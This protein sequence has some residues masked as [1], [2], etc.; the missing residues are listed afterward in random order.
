MKNTILRLSTCLIIGALAALAVPC[1]AAGLINPGFED[2]GIPGDP[3]PGWAVVAN[4]DP[5]ATVVTGGL[6][7]A[8]MLQFP[9]SGCSVCNLPNT[10]YSGALWQKFSAVQ[11]KYYHV[12]CARSLGFQ[13][14]GANI[15]LGVDPYGGDVDETYSNVFWWTAPTGTGPGIW[16][17]VGGWIQC[18]GNSGQ[19]TV[20]LRKDTHTCGDDH[21]D[22]VLACEDYF[23]PGLVN[24]DFESAFSYWYAGP[25]QLFC[26]T[27]GWDMSRQWEYTSD[28]YNSGLSRDTA[29]VA[30]GSPL[31]SASLQAWFGHAGSGNPNN[32]NNCLCKDIAWP[33]NATGATITV[34]AKNF[35]PDNGAVMLGVIPDAGNFSNQLWQDTL[36]H[37]DAA[38]ADTE[39][40][41]LEVTVAKPSSPGY[42]TVMLNAVPNKVTDWHVNYDDFQ[43]AFT[44]TP[45]GRISD[46]KKQPDGSPV[47]LGRKDFYLKGDPSAGFGYIE[48]PDR[49][50][51]IQVAY[52]LA[53]VP[54]GQLVSLVGTFHAA[55]YV[56]EPFIAVSAITPAGPVSVRPLGANNR[57]LSDPLARGLFVKTFGVVKQAGFDWYVISDGSDDEGIPVYTQGAAGVI[58]GQFVAVTG[59]LAYAE[60]YGTSIWAYK[61]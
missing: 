2:A 25:T 48:E 29:T 35:N 42:F 16:K 53:A 12:V 33:G 58:P 31:G 43:V 27:A 11:G 28:G 45:D 24:A 54:Q 18:F 52:N 23:S 30:P 7:G 10:F 22:N 40:H 61:P 46:V 6:A 41:K 17:P 57:S 5:H 56:G 15:K 38:A 32:T 26:G 37:R 60:S 36:G 20:F 47:R 1:L 59:A 13:T 3:I 49:T 39:W 34:Y 8:R 9:C 21:L 50:C 44:Y 55:S 51:G 14:D 4:D 19:M